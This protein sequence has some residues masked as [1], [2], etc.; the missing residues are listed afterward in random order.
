MI[1]DPRFSF[2]LRFFVCVKHP[3]YTL[4]VEKPWDFQG[5]DRQDCKAYVKFQLSSWRQSWYRNTT[6]LHNWNCRKASKAEWIA[7]V[8]DHFV[9]WRS[10]AWTPK[11]VKT[12]WNQ[13][14]WNQII[15]ILCKKNHPLPKTKLSAI[16]VIR[17]FTPAPDV[18]SVRYF[19]EG[20]SAQERDRRGRP[21]DMFCFALGG[22]GC[23]IGGAGVG[24]VEWCSCCYI[25]NS[26]YRTSG[27]WCSLGVIVS[28]SVCSSVC[29][30]T[31]R[32]NNFQ[33]F[34]GQTHLQRAYKKCFF[35]IPEIVPRYQPCQDKP[36]CRLST[37]P[38]WRRWPNWRELG[39]RLGGRLAGWNARIPTKKHWIQNTILGSN[40]SPPKVCFK[41]IFLFPRWDMLVSW[42]VVFVESFLTLF[43]L[44]ESEWKWH[45]Q[46][47]SYPGLLDPFHDI[48]YQVGKNPHT[49]PISTL[50]GRLLIYDHQMGNHTDRKH[51][52]N[53]QQQIAMHDTSI[54]KKTNGSLS[55]KDQIYLSAF[56]L[57]IFVEDCWR[58]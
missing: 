3:E 20:C 45:S 18:M 1:D 24:G 21:P 44:S 6:R 32:R 16:S 14:I 15:Q 26:S 52:K 42:R 8:E 38:A 7:N 50:G 22:G 5:F 31:Q 47:S 54:C 27:P 29:F 4:R 58:L 37:A 2:F 13:K 57:S 36:Q 10:S 12:H 49:G 43:H 19:C 56:T 11:S 46:D 33:N 35:S 41:M 40:I 55:E 34:V 25:T 28:I 53:E 39:T 9:P 48:L 30:D 17:S 23:G 51:C